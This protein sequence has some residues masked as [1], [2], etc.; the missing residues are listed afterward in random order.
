M[1]DRLST[2]EIKKKIKTLD[3]VYH[4]TENREVRRQMIL[5]LDELKLELLK[6]GINDKSISRH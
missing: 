4:I 1:L 3:A 6:R 2:H 5:A